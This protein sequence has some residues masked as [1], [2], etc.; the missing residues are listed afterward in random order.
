MAVE[1]LGDVVSVDALELE[2]D[3]PDPLGRGGGAEDA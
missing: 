2:G 3:G 1:D